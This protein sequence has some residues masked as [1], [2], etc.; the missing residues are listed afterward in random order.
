MTLWGGRVRFASYF[1][2]GEKG[3]YLF[4]PNN[5][6]KHFLLVYEEFPEPDPKPQF[7]QA[8]RERF[9]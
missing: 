7:Y 3:N 9:Y 2:S 1:T 5:I 6:S 8:V 4:L